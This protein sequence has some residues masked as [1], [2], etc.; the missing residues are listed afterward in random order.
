MDLRVQH[1]HT[2]QSM[3]TRH[4]LGSVLF[5][6]LYPSLSFAA[7]QAPGP[8]E[9]IAAILIGLERSK[10][11]A[12]QQ[13]DMASLDALFDERLMWVNQNGT[14]LTKA[15]YLSALHNAHRTVAKVA[16]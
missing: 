8:D 3:N 13:Q 2:G 14:L 10:F 4:I 7:D 5:C 1:D 16:P 9:D 11:S 15:A 12:L 6:L